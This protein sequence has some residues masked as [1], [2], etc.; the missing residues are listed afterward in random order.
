MTNSTRFDS[1]EVK[2]HTHTGGKGSFY[3]VLWN[4][5]LS[6]GRSYYETCSPQDPSCIDHVEVSSDGTINFNLKIAFYETG[7]SG[8]HQDV[9]RTVVEKGN[10][11]VYTCSSTVCTDHIN[12]WWTVNKMGVTNISLTLHQTLS[13]DR[14]QY[15]VETE[16]SNPAT[17][18]SIDHITKHIQVTGKCISGS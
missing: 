13:S 7:C 14:G 2:D 9:T 4:I 11:D 1:C 18:T 15:T 10:S 5:D 16:V 17:G 6:T 12:R 3:L 8:H